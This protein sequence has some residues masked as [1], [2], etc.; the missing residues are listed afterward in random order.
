V[1]PSTTF[2]TILQTDKQKDSGKKTTAK[3]DGGNN[4]RGVRSTK[5]EKKFDCPQDNELKADENVAEF[6][7]GGRALLFSLQGA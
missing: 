2:Y 5:F 7:R 6:V 4:W 3:S 1:K